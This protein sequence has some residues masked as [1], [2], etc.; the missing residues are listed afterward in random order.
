MTG[1]AFW[2]IGSRK[3]YAVPK[4]DIDNRRRSLNNIEAVPSSSPRKRRRC[5]YEEIGLDGLINEVSEIKGQLE[6]YKKLSFKH[7]FS[8]SF[9]QSL[10][11]A[12]TCCICRRYPI[13]SPVGCQ[14]CATMVGCQTCIDRYYMGSGGLTK[15]CPK[16]R[17]PRGLSRSFRIRGFDDLI[18]QIRVMENLS[19]DESEDEMPGA[20]DDTLPIVIPHD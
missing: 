1:I 4:E 17:T 3:I 5:S 9:L 6:A 12:F 13:I 18:S 10:E 2:K 19:E 15:V 20:F 8:L 11:D 7:K 14:Q 16:C